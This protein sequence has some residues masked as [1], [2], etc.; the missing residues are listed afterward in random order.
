MRE[1][2]NQKQ[3]NLEKIHDMNQRRV[4]NSIYYI[5]IYI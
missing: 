1:D 4:S 3:K 2:N 5:Y